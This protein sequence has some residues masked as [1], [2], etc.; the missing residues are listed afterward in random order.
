MSIEK[1][2]GEAVKA[3][4]LSRDEAEEV[5]DLYNGY[6][7]RHH[8]AGAADAAGAAKNDVVER[9]TAEAVEKKRRVAIAVRVTKRIEADVASFRNE[10]GRPDIA[11]GAIALLE[12]HGKAPYSSVEGRRKVIIG[13]AHTRMR[14]FLDTFKRTAL[15]GRTPHPAL[16]RNIVRELFGESSGDQAAMALAKMWKDTA[17]WLRQRF[18]RAGGAIGEL[19]NWGLPQSHDAR[20]LVKAGLEKWKGAIRPLLD[21]SRMRHP[22][23]G[24]PVLESDLDGILDNVWADIITDGWASREAAKAPVGRGAL[25]GQ[26][27][28][29]RF[30]VFRDADAWLT[31]QKEF[32]QDNAFGTM[33]GHV[34]LMARDIAA[35]EILGPNPN[36]TIEWLKQRVMRSAAD[37]AAGKTSDFADSRLPGRLGDPLDR[38]RRKAKTLGDMWAHM[39]GSGEVPVA[40]VPANTLAAARNVKGAAVLGGAIVSAIGTDPL[41]S[42]IAREM[43]GLPVMGAFRDILKAGGKVSRRE[44]VDAGLI[45]ESAMNVFRN[46]VRLAGNFS[47]PE[48][49]QWVLDRVLTVSGLVPW[50]QA[51]RHAYGLAVMREAAGLVDKGFDA[52]PKNM[53]TRYRQWGIGPDEW[54]RLRG[55]AVHEDGESGFRLL[56]PQEISA[57]DEG[58]AERWLEMIL[59]DTEYAVPSGTVRGRA[60]LIG[61][62]QPG[63]LWGEVKKSASMFKNFGATFALLYGSRIWWETARSRAGGAAYAGAVLTT[64]TIGGAVSQW[65]KDVAAG[66]DPRPILDEDGSP[67]KFIGAALLQGGGLGIFGDFLFA[68]LNRFGGSLGAT[69]GGPLVDDATDLLNLTAG[70]VVQAMAGEE[71][72]I[73]EEARAFLADHIPGRNIWYFGLAFKRVLLDQLQFMTDRRANE[74]FKRQQRYWRNNYGSEFWWKPGEMLPDRASDFGAIGR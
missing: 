29:H 23:T 53:A 7:E 16:M 4:L 45:M 19:E 42:K 13:Q 57:I 44:A 36:A 5:R 21:V 48:W 67:A 30:L 8:A 47:G 3:G 72:N 69:L 14:R 46:E 15:L 9:L 54:N 40:T 6:L 37:K 50:T 60:V 38:A 18:N 24:A 11:E 26:R 73:A 63:T 43:A 25:A 17:E 35:L 10:F 51:A 56:R 62:D 55:A 74:R 22:L 28:E 71:T 61:G 34:N 49:S 52:L 70:N 58:L 2:I 1:C 39:R 66:R 64:L 27:A 33:M 31:Y 41:F 32:G 59:Q 65:A 68:D 20:L 12:H